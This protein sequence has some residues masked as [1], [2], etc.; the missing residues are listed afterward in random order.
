MLQSEQMDVVSAF[1]LSEITVAHLDN[2]LS[3]NYAKTV[4]N[5]FSKIRKRRIFN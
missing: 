4:S 2:Y 3:L 1:K 5:Q